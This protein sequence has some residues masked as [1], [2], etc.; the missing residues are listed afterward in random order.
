M[1]NSHGGQLLSVTL[2]DDQQTLWW[3]KGMGAHVEIPASS[4]WHEER[5]D[6]ARR[7]LA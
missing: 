4:T 3:L 5:R 6:D 2:P 7:I 1:R